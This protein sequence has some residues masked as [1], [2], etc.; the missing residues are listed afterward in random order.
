MPTET[1][2]EALTLRKKID[3]LGERLASMF[4]TTITRKATNRNG[5]NRGVYYRTPEFR[6][7]QSRKLK[8]YW[9]KQ[10]AMR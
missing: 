9:R 1:L 2:E 6:A 10:R 3:R 7:N 4:T 8:A 5:N